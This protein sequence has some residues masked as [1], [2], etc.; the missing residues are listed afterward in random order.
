MGQEFTCQLT[1]PGQQQQ[2]HILRGPT[3]S[4]RQP[5]P[6]LSYI[7]GTR[8]LR[9]KSREHSN[10]L[11]VAECCQVCCSSSKS[12][13]IVSRASSRRRLANCHRPISGHLEFL[14]RSTHSLTFHG[15]KDTMVVLLGLHRTK[16]QEPLC[17]RRFRGCFA[18]TGRSKF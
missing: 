15:Q 4:I 1:V 3:F 12:W 8:T 2:P 14:S 16:V 13:P 17:S 18:R 11:S 5:V 7:V 9:T 6:V 10:A